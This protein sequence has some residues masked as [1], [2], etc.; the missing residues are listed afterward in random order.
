MLLHTVRPNIV[1]AISWALIEEMRFDAGGPAGVDWESYPVIR[2]NDIPEIHVELVEASAHDPLGVGECAGGPAAAA[3]G[4]AVAH[5]L[6]MR[7][8]DMPMTRDRVVAAL[9]DT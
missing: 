6:G 9:M 1:Q 5:A 3:I 2:F 4:N 7:I 8:R